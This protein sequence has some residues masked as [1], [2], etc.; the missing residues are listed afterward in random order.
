M[1]H[2]AE[3]LHDDQRA[4]VDGRAD[5]GGQAATVRTPR[6]QSVVSI[7]AGLVREPRRERHQLQHGTGGAAAA[8]ANCKA[9]ADAADERAMS[10][11]QRGVGRAERA[12]VHMLVPAPEAIFIN[13]LGRVQVRC[14]ASLPSCSC[15]SLGRPC[16]L[17]GTS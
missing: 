1:E 13:M 9:A 6:V 15:S 2:A 4:F 14:S 5:K 11:R 7:D 8:D 10:A 3:Q 16:P 12:L 17:T